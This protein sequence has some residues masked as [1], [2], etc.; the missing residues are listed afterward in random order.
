MS[1]REKEKEREREMESR[2]GCECTI[3][4]EKIERSE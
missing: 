4:N 1:R 3:Q 2:R